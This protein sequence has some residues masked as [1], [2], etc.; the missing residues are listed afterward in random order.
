MLNS[1]RL[2]FARRRSSIALVWAPILLIACS[3]DHP[4]LPSAVP[5]PFIGAYAMDGDKKLDVCHLTDSGGQVIDVSTVGASLERL[6]FF[7]GVPD[8]TLRGASVMQVDGDARATG[9]SEAGISTIAPDRGLT[10][11]E[12]LIVVALTSMAITDTEP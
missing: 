5:A 2:P 12:A 9:L 10:A 6:P 1:H 3:A 8:I 7:I 11:A 4:D